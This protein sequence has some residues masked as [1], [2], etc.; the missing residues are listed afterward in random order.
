MPKK[1]AIQPSKMSD[2]MKEMSERLLLDP[3]AA[4]S[5]EAFHVALFFANQAWN[6][7]VGLGAERERT[8]NIWQS[9]EAENPKLW[10][11]LKSR[12]IDG[13]IDELVEY[14]K[15]HYPDDQRRI[16]ACGGTDHSTI[17]V[18]WLPPAAPGVD[19]KWETQLYG[20][21]RGG[22]DDEAVRFLKKTRKMSAVEA[23]MMVTKIATDLGM[24]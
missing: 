5:S 20:M 14:K 2:I 4:H 22:F 24:F 10:D 19:V 6:E 21:V 18:E 12:D 7:C 8:K 3:E 16:L 9:I 11:E 13:M 15:A 17:R 23:R 1:K